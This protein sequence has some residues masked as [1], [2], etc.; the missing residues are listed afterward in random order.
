[1]GLAVPR[2]PQPVF[3]PV[4]ITRK[5]L[6]PCLDN[7]GRF[8]E[9]YQPRFYRTEQRGHARTYIEGLLS[10]LPRKT[11]EPIATDHGQHRKPLQFFVGAGCWDDE[12]VLREL[13]DEVR[14]HLGDPDAV[15][16][17][18]PSAFPKKGR[19]SVG[20]KR[21]WCGRLGKQDNCQLGVFLAYAGSGGTALVDRRLY[22]PR[23]W[24]RDRRRRTK[25]HVPE[26]L[27]FGT[28]AEI[29]N[30]LLKKDAS[31]FPHAWVVGDD[32][33]G[34][35]S[36]FRRELAARQER[37][38]LEVPSNTR[39]RDLE[40]PPTKRRRRQRGARK[41]P[42]V[43]AA[44]WAKQ[45]PLAK[46]TRVFVRDGEKG[47]IEVEAARTAV[48]AYDKTRVGPRETLLVIRTSD[49]QPEH[50]YY[51]SNAEGYVSM[52]EMVRAAHERHHIEECFE[53][54]KSEAGMGHYEV[55]SWVGWHHHTT[56]SLLA[57]WFLTLERRR[58]G[59]KDAGSLGTPGG[60]GLPD[61]LARS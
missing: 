16:I 17:L 9:R 13:H 54:A 53:R 22:L 58:L 38:L 46:W 21:Q 49:P 52:H 35:P 24:C 32:E 4:E 37:Y 57:T 6:E 48:H 29:A 15:L 28:S 56:L 51:L 41:A 43:R 19:E 27:R 14:E 7:L 18:D 12:K 11:C 42:F 44:I 50:R 59:K 8:L 2:S 45:Q 31:R 34:R 60:V 30:D 61:A 40:A 1:M 20:V 25:G 36:W 47:R 55:R 33:M 10:D 23:E 3:H 5:Q 26:E 39:I